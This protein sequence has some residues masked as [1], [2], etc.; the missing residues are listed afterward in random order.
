MY[1][2]GQTG[3]KIGH[4]D[5]VRYESNRS[6]ILLGGAVSVVVAAV[7]VVAYLIGM[8]TDGGQRPH[9]VNLANVHT[10][11]F[12]GD[13]WTRGA[14]AS[15]DTNGFAYL[16]GRTLGVE[17]KVAGFGSVGYANPGAS[18]EGNYEW[19]FENQWLPK[20]KFRPDLVVI[21][22]SVNDAGYAPPIVR[23]SAENYIDKL[24]LKYPHTQIAV[25]GP[26]P[27]ISNYF[28]K[29][30]PVDSALFSASA[31]KRV[32]YISPLSERWFTPSNLASYMTSSQ[33]SPHPNDAGHALI[34]ERLVSALRSK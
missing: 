10:I 3:R 19:R 15:R 23:K 34:A 17:F 32:Q 11:L 13:S 7:I 24:R 25:L 2:G 12:F 26:A 33:N 31:T 6:Q 18:K 20:N 1:T 9:H 22:G 8:R 21:Q 29:L 30:E 27:M 14:S 4:D 28:S 5:N 16:S